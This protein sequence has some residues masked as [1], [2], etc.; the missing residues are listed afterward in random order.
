M[1]LDEKEDYELLNKIFEKLLPVNEDFTA[2]DV[3]RLIKNEPELLEIN[4]NVRQKRRVKDNWKIRNPKHGNS[5]QLSK[6]KYQNI[7]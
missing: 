5:K 7:F 3:I 1:T 4:K 6:F 2:L